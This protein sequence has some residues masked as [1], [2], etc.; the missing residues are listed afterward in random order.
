MKVSPEADFLTYC[1]RERE[2]T[3]WA[4]VEQRARAVQ[5]WQRVVQ[6]CERHKIAPLLLSLFEELGGRGIPDR[7]S[8]N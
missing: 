5:D 4:G 6:L 3:D 8:F 2:S 1:C 7:L